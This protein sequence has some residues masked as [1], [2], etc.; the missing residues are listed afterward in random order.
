[1]RT[2]GGERPK[3]RF[4]EFACVSREFGPLEPASGPFGNA[5]RARFATLT[6]VRKWLPGVAG[7]AR[8]LPPWKRASRAGRPTCCCSSVAEVSADLSETPASF[9]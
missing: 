1:M 9:V 3:P 7:V 4:T 5:H 6:N 8:L 2:I